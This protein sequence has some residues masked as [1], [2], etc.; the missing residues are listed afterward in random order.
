M[1]HSVGISSEFPHSN[2]TADLQAFGE[3]SGGD[4]SMVPLPQQELMTHS[5]HG[6]PFLPVMLGSQGIGGRMAQ[7]S[8]GQICSWS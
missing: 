8:K 5:S 7:V 3:K 6:A 1:E 4:S 2:V